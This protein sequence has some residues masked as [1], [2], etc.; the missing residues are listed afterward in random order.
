MRSETYSETLRISNWVWFVGRLKLMPGDAEG[1][2]VSRPGMGRREVMWL[3]LAI[4]WIP[5]IGLE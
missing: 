2:F 4:L 1:L 5:P 3:V